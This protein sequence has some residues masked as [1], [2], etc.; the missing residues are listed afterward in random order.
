MPKRKIVVFTAMPERP[1]F[2][3]PTLNDLIVILS[4]LLFRDGCYRG[5][6]KGLFRNKNLKSFSTNLLNLVVY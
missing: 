4:I 6:L 3:A 2:L 5:D 1:Y